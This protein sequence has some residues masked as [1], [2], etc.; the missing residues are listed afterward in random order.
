ML[1]CRTL[2]C[3]L[4]AGLIFVFSAPAS[5]QAPDA[6]GTLVIIGEAEQTGTPDIALVTVG[7]AR[8]SDTAAAAL[9]STNQAMRDIIDLVEKRGVRGRDIQTSNL[10]LQPRY[11]RPQR[12]AGPDDRPVITGYIASNQLSLKIRNIETLGR[13]LDD[14]VSA[15]S[16][17]I[18]N[19]SFD[20]D[21]RSKMLEQA[22]FQAVQDARKK[23]A[24]YAAAADIRL[25]EI[26]NLQE[27]AGGAQPRTS[28][29]RGALES[30]SAVPIETGEIALRTRVRIIW[31]IAR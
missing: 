22:R 30:A 29:A 28:A 26:V 20:V 9:R 23:A 24:L 19:L 8:E 4:I 2:L 18:R 31:R 10:S 14:V 7:V 5:A 21:D 6:P 3:A 13:L 1:I 27:E 17:E 11:G 15:G 12:A 16:N 25:G